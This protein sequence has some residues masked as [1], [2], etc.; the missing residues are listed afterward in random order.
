VLKLTDKYQFVVKAWA[1][2]R[3]KGVT[4]KPDGQSKAFSQVLCFSTVSQK[5]SV[6]CLRVIW[7]MIFFIYGCLYWIGGPK[8]KKVGCV[9]TDIADYYKTISLF[10]LLQ[11]I[12]SFHQHF[13]IDNK[14]THAASAGSTNDV[15][16]ITCVYKV[17][18]V[19]SIIALLLITHN[20]SSHSIYFIFVF[21]FT[22]GGQWYNQK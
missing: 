13:C 8:G 21:I 19:T 18:G 14:S 9:H 10:A 22:S 17:P 1:F 5:L 20:R 6:C 2:L 7:L 12:Y 3:N 4:P 16:Y 15:V 11:E